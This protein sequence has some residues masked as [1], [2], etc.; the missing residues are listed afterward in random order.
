MSRIKRGTTA[1]KRRKSVLKLAKGFKWGRKSKYRLAKEAI[2][3]A[4]KHAYSGRKI[5]KRDFRALWIARLSA[6][7]KL[8]GT[9]YSKLTGDLA[10]RKVKLNR[11][12][13]SELAIHHP[14]VFQKIVKA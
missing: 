5:K 12:V 11:K 7:A 4:G 6:A 10:K 14:D 13:L 1:N 9:S 2:W 8:Q 3:H